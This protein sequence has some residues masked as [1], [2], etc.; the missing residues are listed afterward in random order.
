[1]LQPHHVCAGA[2]TSKDGKLLSPTCPNGLCPILLPVQPGLRGS[3]LPPQTGPP[4][5]DRA[6]L[7]FKDCGTY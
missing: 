4:S 6:L 3:W 7:H 1:M 5:A 2:G